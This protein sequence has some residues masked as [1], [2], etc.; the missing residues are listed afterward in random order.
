MPQEQGRGLISNQEFSTKLRLAFSN[1]YHSTET[2]LTFAYLVS[3]HH[4]SGIEGWCS[5]QWY[6]RL[7]KYLFAFSSMGSSGLIEQSDLQM[8]KTEY[9]F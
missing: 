4:S 6:T 7:L 2:A 3:K 9:N 1:F 8:E 5:D